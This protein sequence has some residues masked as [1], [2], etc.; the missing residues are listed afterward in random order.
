[1]KVC[2]ICGKE[3]WSNDGDN[4]CQQCDE[5]ESVKAEKRASRNASRKTRESIMRSMGLVKVRGALGGVYWE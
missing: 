5:L 2:E 1:M 3:I 4:R